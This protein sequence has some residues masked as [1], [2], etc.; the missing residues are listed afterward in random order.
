MAIQ[1]VPPWGMSLPVHSQ[2]PDTLT[3]GARGPRRFLESLR[4]A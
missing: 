2:D 1:E 4:V 3:I